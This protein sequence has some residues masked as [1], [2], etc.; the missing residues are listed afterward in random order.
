V[1][2]HSDLLRVVWNIQLDSIIRRIEVG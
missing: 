1:P 2:C